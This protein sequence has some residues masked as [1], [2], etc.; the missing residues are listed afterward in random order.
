[1]GRAADDPGP[2]DVAAN[3]EPLLEQLQAFSRA[4]GAT[5]AGVPSGLPTAAECGETSRQQVRGHLSFGLSC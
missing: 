5:E 2:A 4:G 3:E 1:M